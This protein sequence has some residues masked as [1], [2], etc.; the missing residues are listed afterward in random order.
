MA[1]VMQT[2]KVSLREFVAASERS[3]RNGSLLPSQSLKAGL[4]PSACAKTLVTVNN[5]SGAWAFSRDQKR[6]KPS[7][8]LQLVT[9]PLFRIA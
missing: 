2:H 1:I 8:S 4:A 7:P 3:L 9:T 6:V 5:A